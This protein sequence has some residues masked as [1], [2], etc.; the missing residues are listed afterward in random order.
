MKSIEEIRKQINTGYYELSEH[1]F[2]KA[3]ER[4]ILFFEIEEAGDKA[5]I[6][7]NYPDDKYSPSCLLLGF[8]NAGKALHLVVSRAKLDYIKIITVYEPDEDSFKNLA[9]R[10]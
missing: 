10:R 8:T 9:D 4:K 2:E 6:I 1:A 3:V 5:E 7:E